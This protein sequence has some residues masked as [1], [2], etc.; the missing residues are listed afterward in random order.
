MRKFRSLLYKDY[1]LLIRDLAGLGLMFLMPVA[2]VFVMTFLQ[3]DILGRMIETEISVLMLNMDKDTLGDS[4][5]S[6]I[7]DS[8]S[9]TLTLTESSEDEVRL[10][11]ARGDYMIGIV[12]PQN[13]S[14]SIRVNAKRAVFGGF[15]GKVHE[16]IDTVTIRIYLDPTL[17]TSF[18]NTLMSTMKEYSAKT[19]RD[20]LLQELFVTLNAY[21]PFLAGS[22][23]LD[24][25]QVDFDVQYA[26]KDENSITPNATQHNVP[27][28]TLFAIFFITVSL[29]VGVINERKEGSFK[30]LLTMPCSYSQYLLSKSVLFLFVCLF[31]FA[32]LFALGIY[33]FP[34]IGLPKLSIG[35]NAWLLL[36][37]CICSSLSAI[38]FGLFIGKITT[39]HQQA[40]VL[41]ALT[42]VILAAIGGIWVPVFT[43]PQ[44]MK[45][46]SQISP[47]NWGLNGFYDIL[48]RNGSLTDIL[49]E[50]L[51]SLGFAV[52][53][54]A[55]AVIYHRKKKL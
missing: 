40:A 10:S 23:Q 43:M 27:A 2:L 39:D 46:I 35:E 34:Y 19:E 29:S 1:L 4:I 50:C 47:L 15:N 7:S 18:R 42:V 16:N 11:V 38:G 22:I 8:D 6:Q 55:I 25:N 17:K 26:F 48:I 13:A 37:M 44:F 30:R 51:Y 21:F 53:C 3:N 14:D 28:W 33:L 12:I 9:F 49:P 24:V 31:Q 32:I 41:S 36:P 5:E 45:T 52:I 20:F 54:M